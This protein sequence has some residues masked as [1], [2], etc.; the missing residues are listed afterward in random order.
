MACL[1]LK[2]HLRRTREKLER[3]RS[4]H[5][6]ERS[7]KLCDWSSIQV[8]LFLLTVE[9]GIVNVQDCDMHW[10]LS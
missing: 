3:D 6:C 1:L 5:H 7:L 9:A 10:Y 2:E 4:E 8:S